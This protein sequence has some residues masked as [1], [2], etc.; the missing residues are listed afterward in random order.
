[1]SKIM[2]SMRLIPKLLF[3]NATV[4]ETPVSCDKIVLLGLFTGLLNQI[5]TGNRVSDAITFPNG[6]L[7][8]SR[9]Y[10]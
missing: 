5:Q 6:S 9:E 10:D 1:M 7:G 4:Q 2:S 3:G 8:T